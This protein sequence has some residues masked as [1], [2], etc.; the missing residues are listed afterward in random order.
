M[1]FLTRHRHIF[2]C[3]VVFTRGLKSS[4]IIQ[5]DVLSEQFL[6]GLSKRESRTKCTLIPGDGVGPELMYSLE[7][8]FQAANCPVDFETLDFSEVHPTMSVTLK[9]VTKSIQKNKICV[10]GILATPEFSH[11]GELQTL[12]MK[13]R[14]ELDLFA[15]VVHV[16][17][18]VGVK[19]RHTDIDCVIIRE[20]TEGEYSAL[21]HEAVPGVVECIKIITAKKSARIAKFAFDYAVKNQRKKVTCVHKANIMKLGDGLFLKCCEK[22]SKL[23]PR[24]QFERMIVDNA[25]MQMVSKPNQFDVMV[26]SNLY[27]NILNNIAC[28]LVGGAGVVA[29]AGYS[30]KICVF[31]PGARHTFKEATGRNVANPTAILLCGAKLLRHINLKSYSDMIT[32]AINDV[33]KKGKIRTKDLGGHSTTT[34]FTHAVIHSLK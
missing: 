23:Y 17:S 16:R 32:N 2:P 18:L 8:V 31:E 21:E 3:I 24:I 11:T 1:S 30:E 27:G 25:T 22:I 28:G 26:T 9:D 4:S 5:N 12:N 33:L 19:C 29:G 6:K 7:Q 14:K 15:N 10:K 34:D 20:Q 13:L